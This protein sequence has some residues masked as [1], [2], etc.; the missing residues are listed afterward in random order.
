M[1]RKG[2]ARYLRGYKKNCII[3]TY[4]KWTERRANNGK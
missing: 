4:L 1:K 2:E 3:D